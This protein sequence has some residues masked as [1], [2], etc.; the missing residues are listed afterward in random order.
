LESVHFLS[1]APAQITW[2]LEGEERAYEHF[3]PP[4]LLTTTEVLRRIR[5]INYKIFPDNQLLA[6]EVS[7]YDTRVILEGLHNCI[8]HQDYTLCSRIVVTEKADRLIFENAGS[9]YEGKPEDYFSGER[10][11]KRYRNPWLAQAMVNLNMIDTVGRA[12]HSFDDFGPAAALLAPSRF[13]PFR[14]K[15]SSSGDFR[16]CD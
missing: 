6:T 11:P 12:G 14:A 9:F 2:K 8:A 1:P 15:P 10:T 4:F 3:G 7:K 13:H 16:S 5:N